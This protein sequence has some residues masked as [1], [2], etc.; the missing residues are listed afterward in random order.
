MIITIVE[1]KKIKELHY[2]ILLYFFI[3]LYIIARVLILSN[4]LVESL[5]SLCSSFAIASISIR[6]EIFSHKQDAQSQKKDEECS[7]LK[8]FEQPPNSDQ[9]KLKQVSGQIHNLS[10]GLVNPSNIYDMDY[11]Q[12]F[13]MRK[14][15]THSLN[16]SIYHTKSKQLSAKSY[17]EKQFAQIIL[18]QIRTGIALINSQFQ[19]VYT[20]RY[21]KQQMNTSNQSILLQKL[22]GVEIIQNQ[23][24]QED[25]C[26]VSETWSKTHLN[27]NE[28]NHNNQEQLLQKQTLSS[29]KTNVNTNSSHNRNSNH[30]QNQG[31]DSHSSIAEK[32]FNQIETLNNITEIQSRLYP[33]QNNKKNNNQ[34][35]NKLTQQQL[36]FIENKTQLKQFSQSEKL[37]PNKQQ[38]VKFQKCDQLLNQDLKN[39]EK[40]EEKQEF[41]FKQNEITYFCNESKCNDEKRYR[42]NLKMALKNMH[43]LLIPPNI[44]Q[45]FKRQQLVLQD[46]LEYLFECQEKQDKQNCWSSDDLNEKKKTNQM[47]QDQII[48][49]QQEQSQNII[50]LIENNN[51]VLSFKQKWDK[52]SYKKIRVGFYASKKGYDPSELFTN[53]VVMIEVLEDYELSK[54]IE[55]HEINEY[56]NRMLA[57]VSHELRT[58]LN[59][60]IQ[61]L[62]SLL[63]RDQEYQNMTP[64]DG[65]I[66]EMIIKPALNS[67]LLL[68]NIINDILDYGQINQGKLELQFQPF[69]IVD[70]ITECIDLIY[71]QANQK[72]L[73]IEVEFDVNLPELIYSDQGRLKQ[74]LLNLL[75]NSLKFTDA[76]TIRVNSVVENFDLIRIDVSDTGCGIPE[77]NLEKVL[78]AFGNKSTGKFLNTIGAG[79]G[80]SIANNLALG[81]GGNRSIQI[82]SKVKEGSTFTFYVINRA[83]NKKGCQYKLKDVFNLKLVRWETLNRL[84]VQST[85]LRNKKQ[86][87]KIPSELLNN[88]SDFDNPSPSQIDNQDVQTLSH[89]TNTFVITYRPKSDN[90]KQ[91]PTRSF[92]IGQS[93][94]SNQEI[95]TKTKQNSS[96]KYTKK[97]NSIVDC[98]E[99]MQ[100][101]NQ[102]NQ[103]QEQQYYQQDQFSCPYLY[104]SEQKLQIIESC[105][106]LEDQ[107]SDLVFMFASDIPKNT[108]K[109]YFRDF[110]FIGDETSISLSHRRSFDTVNDETKYS[111]DQLESKNSSSV[112]TPK[113]VSLLNKAQSINNQK[114]VQ[115]DKNNQT[116]TN[117]LLESTIINS[118]LQNN[119]ILKQGISSQNSITNLQQDGKI[120]IKQFNQIQSC[121]CSKILVVDDNDFN[122]Y[123]IQMC[124]KQYG[125]VSEKATSGFMAI[126]KIKQK[127]KQSDCCLTYKLIFM[128][129]DMPIKDGYETTKNILQY[130]Q[131]K[132]IP[133]PKISACTAYVQEKERK[134]AFDC[135]MSYYLT[136]PINSF[137]LENI[138]KIEFNFK[139]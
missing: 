67:N 65:E 73:T 10:H 27:N 29:F 92:S 35:K 123:A 77:D 2:I 90:L 121:N 26:D 125:F 126:D 1:Q 137:E 78:Q 39:G 131:K 97:K 127:L 135:G 43:Q 102:Q 7:Q 114:A 62:Q 105:Q 22:L 74:V 138:L 48:E 52:S 110:L 19:L 112:K 41:S 57:S 60:S 106:I 5:Y 42:K 13:N 72:G 93:I 87:T 28:N 124:L 68:L 104:K 130:F 34:T 100:H 83:K 11:S 58:P 61:L 119:N 55:D 23:T 25:C 12:N 75:S 108:T 94:K 95:K 96:T 46:V 71:F 53:G 3:A 86:K 128:D 85:Y 14:K 9:V 139:K 76:G 116:F 31:L 30:Q 18:S 51:L 79:F 16:N 47:Q 122:L 103:I 98:F 8:S 15:Q 81:L 89:K 40:Q 44:L 64:L 50:Y 54:T 63:Q 6:N 33:N 91:I 4:F 134:K 82:Q 109:K 118:N 113:V 115:F 32:R 136:K 49:A 88:K 101:I 107:Q 132:N 80:M 117:K 99:Q 17:E 21:L 20:N 70:A 66:K 129:I 120:V 69:S 56:K 84:D 133:P 111:Q 37:I 36:S 45:I 59:C 38:R 24:S